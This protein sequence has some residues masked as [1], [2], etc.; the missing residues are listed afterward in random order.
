MKIKLAVGKTSNLYEYWEESIWKYLKESGR[1]TLLMC[2]SKEYSKAVATRS[3]DFEI[4]TPRF[5]QRTAA[6]PKEKG[7]FAKY[8]RG[9]LARWVIDNRVTEPSKLKDFK[10]DGF[11]YSQDL[12][13]KNEIVFIIPEDFTLKGRFVKK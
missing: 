13:S 4:I 1:K 9:L 12:S 2:A 3:G 10:V 6:G 5:M 7:L 8:G 11:S